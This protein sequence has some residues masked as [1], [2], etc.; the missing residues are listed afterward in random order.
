MNTFI[1]NSWEALK[2]LAREIA[3][4]L[5]LAG[6]ETWSRWW[7]RAWPDGAPSMPDRAPFIIGALPA[8]GVTFQMHVRRYPARRKAAFTATRRGRAGTM[9]RPRCA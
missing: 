2:V 4:D 1:E 6:E 8:P 7:R 5:R 9:S 3:A